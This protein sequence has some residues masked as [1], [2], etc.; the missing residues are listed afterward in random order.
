MTRYVALLRGINVGGQKLIKM[1]ELARIFTGAGFKHVR[2]YQ[3][4]GNVIFDS[5]SANKAALGKKIEKALQQSLGYE[6]TVVLRTHS[7]LESL[8]AR[9]P[10]RRRA[11]GADVMQCVV[12]LSDD[13]ANK[14][15]I[16]I[17]S[18]TD[19]LKVFAVADRA[20]FVMMRRKK[21][22]WFGFPNNFV[23]KQF[24]VLGTTRQWSTVTK[25]LKAAEK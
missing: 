16:P 15:Q 17:I 24:G 1:E 20:A 4:S 12:F 9:N 25:I 18:S 8:V 23:E 22:G 10:F 2:T 19:N 14:I 13:P 6:V 5:P 21:T 7:E 11:S 3:A